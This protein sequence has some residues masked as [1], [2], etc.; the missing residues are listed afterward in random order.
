[1]RIS[2]TRS[3][4]IV[5]ISLLKIVSAR[6]KTTLHI[7]YTISSSP[8]F[9]SL[10]GKVYLAS[11]SHFVSLRCKTIRTVYYVYKRI[12]VAV[13]FYIISFRRHRK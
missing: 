5:R 7:C 13:V 9:W 6:C 1:M 8:C 3:L 4:L 11:L 12:L 2:T 10:F